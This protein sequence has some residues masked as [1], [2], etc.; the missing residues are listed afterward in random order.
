MPK[1]TDLALCQNFRIILSGFAFHISFILNIQQLD[2]LVARTGGTAQVHGSSKSLWSPQVIKDSTQ[3][4]FPLSEI[5]VADT[6]LCSK[7]RRA[8]IAISVYS[9]H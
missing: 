9:T 3:L 7:F 5:Q 4:H 1:F 2:Y 6:Q 8:T